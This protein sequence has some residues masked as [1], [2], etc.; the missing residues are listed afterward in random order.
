[1][2]PGASVPGRAE[3]RQQVRAGEY[4]RRLAHSGSAIFV[5]LFLITGV[6]TLPRYGATWDESLGNM[7]FGDRYLH[8]FGT[9]NPKYLDFKADLA[10][11]REHPLNLYLSPF[12]DTPQEFPALADTLS[13]AT[14]YLFSYGLK[15]LNPIDG[16]HLFSVLASGLLLW[17]LYRFVAHRMGNF[18]AWMAVLFLATF[19]R[20]WADMHFN[21]KDVPETV[22]FGL[23]ILSFCTWHERPTLRRAL[24]TGILM[25]CAIG[26]KANAI[27]IPV[28]LLGGI[29]PWQ[30]NPRV[31]RETI[32][33]IRTQAGHYVLMLLSAAS[34][35]L[36]SWPYL[37]A[38]PAQRLG[39]YWSYILS[40]GDR[41][42]L[43]G[44]H[45][46]PIHLVL[47][48]MPEVML[49]FL[50]IGLIFVL[51]RALRDERPLWRI[52]LL[53]L[54]I[55]IARSSVPG[56]VNFD[57]IRHFLEFL[58]AAALVAG[59]AASRLMD[60]FASRRRVWRLAAQ[61]AVV[62]LLAANSGDILFHYYPYLHLYYNRLSG[63]LASA[64]ERS[65]GVESS[66]YWATS[67]RQ[68]MEWLNSHA[69]PNSHLHALIANWIVQV[70]GPVILRQDIQIS[71]E[72][73]LPDFDVMRA[74]PSPYYLMFILRQ[75]GESADEIAYT[76]K[77]G[78]LVYQVVVD[79]V[80]ILVIYR[81][82][83]GI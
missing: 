23:A 20:F 69:P 18:A 67:Y 47:E 62:L 65:A 79:S 27:F 57:G 44:W 16:F 1:M 28:I 36:L 17:C 72:G 5:L 51:P 80:P 64:G 43:A 45:F 13:A 75:G 22:F 60:L 3:S 4:R 12:R 2:E 38:A 66:D 55:H 61:T 53:W 70:S 52:I 40:Q 63:G 33:R 31:Y 14:M 11:L 73:A 30:L 8:Y 59:Y 83:G 58:P 81:F 26:V 56:A 9:F 37:Y 48:T 54:I 10:I 35:Y 41:T 76:I 77:H 74:S 34:I 6:L 42:G 50:G 19:P 7:F 21:P 29:L 25:G 15:W 32:Y 39:Q 71:P 68:G 78:R 82:G 46:D 49:V 24:Q